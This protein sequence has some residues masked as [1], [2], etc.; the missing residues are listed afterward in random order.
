MH[1]NDVT[2]YQ[3]KAENSGVEWCKHGAH[4]AK[5]V[6]HSRDDVSE[7]KKNQILWYKYI[8]QHRQQSIHLSNNH[9]L[10]VT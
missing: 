4:K 1:L 2:T 8:L 3:L 9:F 6:I 10:D 5:S 7:A